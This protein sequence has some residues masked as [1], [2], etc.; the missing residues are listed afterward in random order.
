MSRRRVLAVSG[1]TLGGGAAALLRA[2]DVAA[3][4]AT[5]NGIDVAD[6]THGTDDGEVYTPWINIDAC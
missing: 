3:A 6:A 4:E 1:A 2:P 5:V